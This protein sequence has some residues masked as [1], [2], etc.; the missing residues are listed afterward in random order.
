MAGD[1][2]PSTASR[3]DE[4][5]RELAHRLV[6]AFGAGDLETYFACFADDATFAF[7]THP[8]VLTS[9]QAHRRQRWEHEDAFTVLGCATSE[10]HW[11][12]WSDAA[13]LVHRVATTVRAAGS[14]SALD[15][16]GTIVFHRRAQGWR[17]VHEH[18]FVH[19]GAIRP[20]G[21]AVAAPTPGAPV[22]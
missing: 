17:A 14:E 22:S 15:E 2:V 1:E 21:T 4:D 10:A 20:T 7:P 3:R 5:V 19:P 8:E 6:A 9:L 18:L 11:Q 13:V 16:R 12:V